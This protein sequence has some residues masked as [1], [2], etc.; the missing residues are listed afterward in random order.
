MTPCN[1]SLVR[2]PSKAG[3]SLFSS[4]EPMKDLFPHSGTPI[5][6]VALFLTAFFDPPTP[7]TLLRP[8]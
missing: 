2:R 1:R 5:G 4:T 3:T 7:P 8:G 6:T